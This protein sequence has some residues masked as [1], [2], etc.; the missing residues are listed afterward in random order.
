MSAFVLVAILAQQA[1]HA[2]APPPTPAA[3][4]R[5]VR[6]GNARFAQALYAELGKGDGNLCFSPYSISAAFGMLSA[7][8]RGETLAQVEKAFHLPPQAELHPAMK[9]L[10][11]ELARRNGKAVE[12]LTANALWAQSGYPVLP[13]FNET[14]KAS[15]GAEMDTADFSREPEVSRLMLNRWVALQTRRKIKDL[16]PEGSITPATRLVLANAVF[17]EAAW[18]K[19]FKVEHTKAGVFHAPAG[20]VQAQ[21]MS[22]TGHFLT[23]ATKASRLIELP[24]AGGELVLTLAAARDGLAAVEKELASGDLLAALPTMKDAR[25][26]LRMPR[27]K[28]ATSAD[29]IPALKALGVTSLFGK[30][31]LRGITESE[32]LTVSGVFHKA[33]IEIDEEGGRA[34]AATGIV[35]DSRS[36]P[37]KFDLDRPFLFLLR[38]RTTGTVLFLGRV[39]DPT[40]G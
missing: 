27:F 8:A 14:L 2:A 9:A 18:V 36:S 5:G 30:A 34:A 4:P 28:L 22:Q 7:G 13:A 1:I 3:G 40:K 19:K 20:D 32:P 33:M 21:M 24:F 15:H 10:R 29:L 16:F 11:D 37:M 6:E 31:D 38:D 23:G 39:T 26:A 12:L 17:F 35:I 25:V